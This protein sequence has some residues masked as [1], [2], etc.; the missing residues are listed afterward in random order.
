MNLKI[1]SLGG[2]VY[3]LKGIFNN[4]QP[5][6]F[7]VLQRGFLKALLRPSKDDFEKNF[8]KEFHSHL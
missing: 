2:Q 7:K 5:R 3:A 1:F 6:I 8:L 4:I